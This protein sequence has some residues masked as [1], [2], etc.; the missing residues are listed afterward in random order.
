MNIATDD[1]NMDSRLDIRYALQRGDFN[2]NV[3]LSIPMQGI[4]GVFGASGSG[5]TTLLRCIAGLE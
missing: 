5:K 3:D 2:L 4:S 1:P